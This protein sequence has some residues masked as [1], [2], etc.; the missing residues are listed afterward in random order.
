[1]KQLNIPGTLVEKAHRFFKLALQ[2]NFT[3]GRKGN[4]VA[5]KWKKNSKK[6]ASCLYLACRLEKTSHMLL[7]FSEQLQV[8]FT[9][10]F[11]IF[12]GRCFSFGLLFLLFN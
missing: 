11:L 1:M 2:N 12:K 9:L 6:K 7:D 8:F 4:H 3:K 5:G 10:I